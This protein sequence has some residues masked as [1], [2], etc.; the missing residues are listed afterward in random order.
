MTPTYVVGLA[1]DDQGR[2][3]LIEKNRPAWQR[4]LLNGIGGKVEKNE[5]PIQ[6]MIREFEE[7]TG[8]R[9]ESWHLFLTLNYPD[10]YVYFFRTRVDSSVLDELENVTDEFLFIGEYEDYMTSRRNFLVR[11]LKWIMPLGEYDRADYLPIEVQVT[12][13]GNEGNEPSEEPSY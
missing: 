4:G 9:I 2:V 8:K 12:G 6:A 11:N 5:M 10:S 13:Y 3:A 7:E 1:F